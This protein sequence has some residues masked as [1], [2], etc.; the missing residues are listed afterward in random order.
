MIKDIDVFCG[1]GHDVEKIPELKDKYSDFLKILDE[2]NIKIHR[3]TEYNHQN[4]ANIA[5]IIYKKMKNA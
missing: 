4:N 5:T 1:S 2:N 3:F